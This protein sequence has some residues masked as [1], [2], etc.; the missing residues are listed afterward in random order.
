MASL[1][2][3]SFTRRLDSAVSG[4]GAALCPTCSMPICSLVCAVSCPK[5]PADSAYFYELQIR[6][7]DEPATIF[8]QCTGCGHNWRE[9]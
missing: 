9:Q 7:A 2:W 5:C 6:S 4:W 1:G 3:R 8:Y